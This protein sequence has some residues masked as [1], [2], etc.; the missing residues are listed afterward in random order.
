MGK[1][2]S[3]FINGS[4]TVSKSKIFSWSSMMVLLIPAFRRQRQGSLKEVPGHPEL[5]S[6]WDPVSKNKIPQ[7]IVTLFLGRPD[8]STGQSSCL[9]SLTGHRS[10]SLGSIRKEKNWVLQAVLC[11][12]HVCCASSCTQNKRK[13]NHL[14]NMLW[15]SMSRTL[16]KKNIH[17]VEPWSEFWTSQGCSGTMSQNKSQS[18][19]EWNQH[20]FLINLNFWESR[21]KREKIINWMYRSNWT[22]SIF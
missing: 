22:I 12:S 10:W 1:N 16:N 15:R 7:Q 14:N 19:N 11:S 20:L 3:N 5:A 21:R 6:Q 2:E 17:W 9:H 18:I 13:R 4:N 8:G